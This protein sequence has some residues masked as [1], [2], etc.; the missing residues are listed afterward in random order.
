M[1][2]GICQLGTIATASRVKDVN[3]ADR[4]LVLGN[5]AC[6]IVGTLSGIIGA[7]KHH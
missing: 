4:F 6:L 1:V 2:Y 7:A 5:G 3:L